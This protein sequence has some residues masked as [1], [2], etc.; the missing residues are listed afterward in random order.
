MSPN[1]SSAAHTDNKLMYEQVR[2][3]WYSTPQSALQ[4]N[5]LTLN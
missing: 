5:M 3:F 4:L 2:L 1:L